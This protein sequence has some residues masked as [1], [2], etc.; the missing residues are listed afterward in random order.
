MLELFVSNTLNR[1]LEVIVGPADKEVP[2]LGRKIST[3]APTTRIPRQSANNK[4][5]VRFDK[6]EDFERANIGFIERKLIIVSNEEKNVIKEEA[7]ETAFNVQSE[8]N[9]KNRDGLNDADKAT[10]DAVDNINHHTKDKAQLESKVAI[11]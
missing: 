2:F 4:V 9:K 11:T 10:K 1:D 7:V 6:M 8:K 5:Y 3:A